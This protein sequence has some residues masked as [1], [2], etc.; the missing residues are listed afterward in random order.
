MGDVSRQ[1]GFQLFIDTDGPH[2]RAA[3]AMRD[4][5][6]LMKIEMADVRPDETR[7]GQTYLGIHIGA[8]HI[9][10]ASVIV[11]D[12]ADLTD[13]F[14]EYAV[15]RSV[16]D[17]ETREAVGVFNGFFFEIADIDMSIF[18]ALYDD[19]A[20]ACHDGA[21]GVGAVCRDRDEHDITV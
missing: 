13:T 3:T 20:H 21:G 9:D 14:F 17:H 7:A 8:V 15:S 10:K 19:D 18:V 5:E 11:D 12:T 16:G 4:G 2:S 6:G 1:I